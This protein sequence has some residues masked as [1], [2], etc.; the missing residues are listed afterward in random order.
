MCFSASK[1]VVV[2]GELNNFNNVNIKLFVNPVNNSG[3]N[4]ICLSYGCASCSIPITAGYDTSILDADRLYSVAKG[5]FAASAVFVDSLTQSSDYTLV[6]MFDPETYHHFVY[7]AASVDFI[8]DYLKALHLNDNFYIRV[9]ALAS[10]TEIRIALNQDAYINNSYYSFHREEI[11]YTLDIGETVVISSKY[12]LTGT[13]VTANDTVSFYSGHYCAPGKTTYCS[14]L[15]E[16]L[17]P[18]NSWGNTFVLRTNVGLSGSIFKFIASDVGALVFMNCTTDGTNYEING[19]KLGFR[20]HRVMSITHDYCTVKSDKNILIIQFRDSSPPLRDTFMTIIPALVHYEN[21]YVLNTYEGF[22]NFIALTGKD[23][24]VATNTILLD[25]SPI[26]LKWKM[27]ELDG[28]AYHFATVFLPSGRHTI[29]FLGKSVEFGVILY[30][31]NK[32]DTYAYPAGMKLNFTGNVPYEGTC[33]YKL[34]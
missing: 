8:G 28:D 22:D 27:I 26:F 25:H 18:Y 11:V 19:I 14:I 34:F 10:D 2:F 5:T 32:N 4:Y 6:L 17:P 13:R 20:D 16:Q 31:L 30:G 9:I 33:M 21:N 1:T 29:A 3:I 7:Y 12:D 15:N 23:A 24:D